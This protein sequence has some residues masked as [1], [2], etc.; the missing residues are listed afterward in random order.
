M[1][2]VN[3]EELEALEKAAIPAPWKDVWVEMTRGDVGTHHDDIFV[4]ELRNSFSDI[5]KELRILREACERYE[6]MEIPRMQYPDQFNSL[7][8]ERN[9]ISAWVK[10]QMG[11]VK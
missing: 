6:G 1:N 8:A 10:E 7:L 5:I 11:E 3:I 9:T 2:Q 4:R